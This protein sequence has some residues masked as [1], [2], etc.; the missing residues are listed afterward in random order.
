M[1]IFALAGLAA[2]V[3]VATAGAGTIKAAGPVRA[4]AVSGTET[5]FAAD[6]G[7]GCAEVRVYDNADRGV[8]RY[9][10][11]CW[12]Q[13]STGSGVAAV[14][15]A[16]ERALWLTYTGGNIRDWT[17]WTRTRR[18]APRRLRTRSRDVDAP[19]PIVV[20][21]ADEQALP[22]SVDDTLYAIAWNGRRLFS[23]RAPARIVTSS[24]QGPL[25][26][27]LLANGDVATLDE[28]GAV[29][30]T[31]EFDPNAVRGITSVRDGV[32]VMKANALE[33]H[34][35]TQ[36]Q[37]FPV[38][39][40]SRLLGFSAGLV[41]YATPRELRILSLSDGRDRLFQ[42]LAVPVLAG[43]DRRGIG[44]A[45]GSTVNFRAWVYVTPYT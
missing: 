32:I 27:V 10:K 19:A 40:G 43:F 41:A 45:T 9:A 21:T 13:T 33:M 15:V 35:G 26:A 25:F 16:N 37:S 30:N 17:L 38:P 39:R 20:G 31:R 24:A 34:R 18:T 6:L 28:A 11:H 7:R 12:E 2:L 4:L 42:R 22:Y 29:I 3:A 1:R 14:A 44:W 36:V 23:W 8:R 5:V